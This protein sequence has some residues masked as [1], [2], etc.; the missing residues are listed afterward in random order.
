MYAWYSV[1]LYILETQVDLY[2]KNH[3]YTMWACT[4]SSYSMSEGESVW[5]VC[6]CMR[7]SIK[8]RIYVVAMVQKSNEYLIQCLLSFFFQGL[9]RGREGT[10]T[11]LFLNVFHIFSLHKSNFSF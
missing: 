9:Q 11:K 7:A 3:T 10:I 1:T 5:C 6:V 2:S 4:Q 8:T